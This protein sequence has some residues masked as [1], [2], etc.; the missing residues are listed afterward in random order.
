MRDVTV[1]FAAVFQE[2][3]EAV[4][5]HAHFESDARAVAD[6]VLQ[7][8]QQ[9][10]ARS[11]ALAQ[12]PE[13][14]L[15]AITAGCANADI[16]CLSPPYDPQ[17]LPNALDGIEIGVTGG[18][19]AIAQTGTIAE[20]TQDDATRI[21]SGLPRTHIAIAPRSKLVP[22][23]LE[24]APLLREHFARHND[25]VAVSFISGPSRTGD[26]E[27]ILTLG[28]HGPETFHAI[29]MGDA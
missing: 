25:H 27:M 4:A 1:D 26:I 21:V 13:A 10:G 22:T 23:L 20:I 29:L 9:A 8:A 17:T 19:F 11:M 14:L 2:A 7:I 6:R 15:E 16:A 5:G 24:A 12:L 18:E 3:L 28:V